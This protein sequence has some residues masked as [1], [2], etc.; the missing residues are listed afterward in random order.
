MLYKTLTGTKNII[1]RNFF[2]NN[3]AI[4]SAMCLIGLSACTSSG[5]SNSEINRASNLSPST[6]INQHN[7]YENS[8]LE[9]GKVLAKQGNHNAAIPLYKSAHFNN[10]SEIEPLL[11]LGE[12]FMAIGRYDDAL[13][14]LISAKNKNNEHQE[15]LIALGRLY[16]SLFKP[17]TAGKYF[18]LAVEAKNNISSNATANAYS[19]LGV[20]LELSGNHAAAQ[21]AFDAGLS[22][23]PDNLNLLS[24]KALSLALSG[25][26]DKAVEILLNIAAKPNAK[27]QHRQNLALAYV[28]QGDSER[29][30]QAASI[31]MTSNKAEQ[32][33][34]GFYILKNLEQENRMHALV[35]GMTAPRTGLERTA[36]KSELKPDGS[37][38]SKRIAPK[39]EVTIAVEA[40]SEVEEN[41]DLPPL[42]DPTG[43]AVQ[44]GAY[45]KPEEI[46]RGWEILKKKYFDIIGNLEPRRSEVN[47][48]NRTENGPSGFY[49]RLNAGPL[50]GY[51]HSRDICIAIIQSGGK[52]WIRP[53]EP[54][55]GKLPE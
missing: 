44:I 28:F 53:P 25:E 31:D 23:N 43:W 49:Y 24:N 22:V 27:S 29:A 54:S 21:Q 37:E 39:T 6:N 45:R 19:G 7:E 26:S 47:F 1:S 13:D 33:V 3:K 9:M 5:W 51:K 40:I 15:V 41:P 38:A 11:K 55:E 8:L 14:V 48:G 46:I 10:K 50:S 30:W 36:N 17:V 18:A 12:S 20:A 4:V 2:P 34:A 42:L 32:I 52:C 35:Y 16:L